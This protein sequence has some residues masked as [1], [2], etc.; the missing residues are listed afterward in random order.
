MST[1][2]R[3]LEIL[4]ENRE[5]FI[6]GEKLAETLELS[7]TSIWKAVKGLKEQGHQIDSQKGYRLNSDLLSNSGVKKFLNQEIDLKIFKTLDST[8]QEAKRMLIDGQKSKM[9]I[10][11]EEQTKGRGRRGREFFSPWG[12]G[13]Y[14][15]IALRPAP[16]DVLMMT[17]AAAVG[18]SRAIKK[19]T[20]IEVSIKWVND[21]YYKDKKIAGILTEGL[22]NLETG[23]LDYLIIGIGL[24]VLKPK[25][26]FPKEIKDIAGFLFSKKPDNLS[27]NQLAAEIINQLME[28]L[29]DEQ[30]DYINEYRSRSMIIGEKIEILK[31][32]EKIPAKVIGID[33]T[34]GLM[35]LYENDISETLY[36]GE[37]SI[38]RIR[39]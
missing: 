33:N 19:L 5:T 20:G 31:L 18:I 39:R 6:S 37:I 30:H 35:V 34:G 7:R 9:I 21:I 26:D 22:T 36:S 38:R 29:R 11:S 24:N 8:N 12:S 13:L 23:M 27:R 16:K 4:E 1:K 10:I 28:I 32:N 15:S 25:E 2:E 14:L 3:V 17:I